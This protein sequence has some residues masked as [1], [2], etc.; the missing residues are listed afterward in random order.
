MKELE[1]QLQARE[2]QV[3]DLE[4]DLDQRQQMLQDGNSR[5]GEL[6]DVQNELESSVSTWGRECKVGTATAGE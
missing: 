3:R 6:E 2:A 4:K 1:T 5:I